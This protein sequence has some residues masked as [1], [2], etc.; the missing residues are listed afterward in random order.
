MRVVKQN[1]NFLIP[2]VYKNEYADLCNNIEMSGTWDKIIFSKESELHSYVHGAF[3]NGLNGIGK[4]Y[5]LNC[6]ISKK[7]GGFSKIYDKQSDV[8]FTVENIELYIFESECM[9]CNLI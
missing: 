8:Y 2:L 5:K 9:F 3:G 7:Y 6:N 4:S 1:S